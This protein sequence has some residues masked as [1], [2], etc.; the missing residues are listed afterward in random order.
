MR[1]I[2]IDAADPSMA[3][4]GCR[5]GREPDPMNP[6]GFRSSWRLVGAFQPLANAGRLSFCGCFFS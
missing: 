2:G 1:E 6:A 5:S 3:N 4:P